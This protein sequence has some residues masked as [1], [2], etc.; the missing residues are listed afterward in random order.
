[1]N[2]VLDPFFIYGFTDNRLFQLLG[3]SGLGDALYAL[4]GFGGFGVQGAAIATVLSRGIGAVIGLAVL[5]TGRVGIH[6]TPAD[7]RLRAGTVREIVAIGGPASID[8]STRAL[9]QTVL[10]AVVS[11]AGPTAVA[12]FGIGNR[13]NSLVFLPS[14]GLAQGT[15]TAVGQN[16]GAGRAERS[17]RAVYYSSGLIVAALAA[18]SVLAWVF[19]EPVV[20]L[21]VGEGTDRAAVVELGVSYLRIIG[22][23]FLFLGVFRVVA[24]AF[25]GSGNTRTAMG[26]TV[27]SLWVFRVPPAYLLSVGTTVTLGGLSLSVPALGATGVWYAIALS[28]VATA[29]L[30]FLWFRRGTWKEAVGGVRDAAPAD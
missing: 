11:L 9:G 3:V 14:I 8:Q 22:P 18:V 24:S 29:V 2:V 21:F 10:T 13:L 1:L 20:S 19:A 4:T 28:N 30:A 5:F 15:T 25:R 27:L 16:L 17:E 23:T 26:F 12:A 7:L 6:V